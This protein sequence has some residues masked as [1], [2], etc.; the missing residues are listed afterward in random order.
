ME[1]G[2]ETQPQSYERS[3]GTD[4]WSLPR[5]RASMKTVPWKARSPSRV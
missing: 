3:H 2:A 5:Q 1:D 4:D